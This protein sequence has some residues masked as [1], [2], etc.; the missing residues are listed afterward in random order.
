MRGCIYGGAALGQGQVSYD[1]VVESFAAR[2]VAFDVVGAPTVR[3]A[4]LRNSTSV[5]VLRRRISD[6]MHCRPRGTAR[7]R[8]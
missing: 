5:S 7:C 3:K 4:S 2:A 8:G 6:S 1:R